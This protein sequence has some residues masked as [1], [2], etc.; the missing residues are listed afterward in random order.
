MNKQETSKC[1]GAYLDIIGKNWMTGVIYYKCSKCG[2]CGKCDNEDCPCHTPVMKEL[3]E[4]KCK[5]GCSFI[6][7]SFNCLEC[8]K[9]R[10]TTTK[11]PVEEEKECIKCANPHLP[12]TAHNIDC[13]NV[14][15][16]DFP[17]QEDTPR[18]IAKEM[19]DSFR[20]TRGAYQG[21]SSN[22]TGGSISNKEDIPEWIEEF[23]KEFEIVVSGSKKEYQENFRLLLD[24]IKQFISK[25]EQQAYE[26]GKKEV[27]KELKTADNWKIYIED[28]L[29]ERDAEIVEICE[30][31]ALEHNYWDEQSKDKFNKGALH[32]RNKFKEFIINIIN[33]HKV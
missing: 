24:N 15:K 7:N 9:S 10:I 21:A 12:F 11:E 2:K 28:E 26:R 22:G 4:E 20:A 16:S 3:A 19:I 1:C 6:E 14:G 17:P 29:K 30:K 5:Y 18:D 23:E 31:Y 13:P 25:V 33:K 27:L 32:E 8:G